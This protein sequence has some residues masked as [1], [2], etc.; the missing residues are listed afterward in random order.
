VTV[1]DRGQGNKDA[2]A[3]Y[4]A[5]MEGPR[6]GTLKHTGCPDLR[7]HVLHAIARRLPGGDHR[8][9]RPSTVRQNARAQDRRVIDALTAA[10]MVV[11]HSTAPCR[12]VRSTR[13]GTQRHEVP[14]Q[15]EGPDVASG[16]AL[17]A[18]RD[19]A[20]NVFP[21]LGGGSRERIQN[22]FNRA[23]SASYGWMYANSPSVRTV[24]DVIVRNVGQLELR[25]FEEI[26]QSER[27]PKPD[28]PAA[29]S[30]RY[31]NETTTS[32]AFI[33]SMFKDFLIYDNA[34]A[35]MMAARRTD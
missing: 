27:Q 1:I 23:Q 14:V 34:Y 32:D 20:W 28:H 7:S 18:M 35:L 26:S 8:F 21:L 12:S 10:A 9:D 6:N 2:V 13:T 5:F 11:E 17:T 4:D 31:P 24:I 22:V 33:R 15:E 19:P 16:D 25:L 29:L 30:L 3:D